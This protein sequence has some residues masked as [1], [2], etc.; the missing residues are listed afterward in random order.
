MTEIVSERGSR[1]A[2][3]NHERHSERMLSDGRAGK[4]GER[5]EGS[6]I[7]ERTRAGVKTA[8]R[9]GAKFGRRPKPTL[10]RL[11]HAQKLIE[12]GKTPNSGRKDHSRKLSDPLPRCSAEQRDARGR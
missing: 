7:V 11:T 12:Q 3:G 2:S 8:R 10:G 1:M 5:F 4:G 9:R 6:L